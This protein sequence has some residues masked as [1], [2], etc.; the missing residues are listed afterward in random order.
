[1]NTLTRVAVII[2]HAAHARLNAQMD[3]QPI[4]EI[5]R[6]IPQPYAYSPTHYVYAWRGV[7]VIVCETKHRRYEVFRVDGPLLPVEN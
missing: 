6:Q 4:G 2:G 5:P 3:E 7:P 1:M